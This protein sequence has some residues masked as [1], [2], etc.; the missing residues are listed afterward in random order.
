MFGAEVGEPNGGQNLAY[1]VVILEMHVFNLES[2]LVAQRVE[3]L[4]REQADVRRIVPFVGEFFG[5]RHAA[6]QHQASASRP[7]SEIREGDDDLL[8][9]AQK[10]VQE[11]DRI[12]DFLNGAVDN[13]VIKAFV[14]DVCDAAVIEVALDHLYVFFKAIE[15]PLDVLF[16]AESR[17]VLFADKVFE[18][19]AAA[20]TEVEHMAAFLNELADKVEVALVVEY[21]NGLRPFVRD[22]F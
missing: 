17:D 22:D 5:N 4:D 16:D 6:M 8:G 7:V 9:D 20:A 10:F 15:D 21:G 19:V 18:H 13:R 14:L 11:G 2:F 12:A 1:F 3:I